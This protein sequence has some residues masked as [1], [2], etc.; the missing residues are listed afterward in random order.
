MYVVR[1]HNSN[2]YIP[3]FAFKE[4]LLQ[5]GK[6]WQIGK[7]LLPAMNT[8]R[9]EVDDVSFPG[10]P[11]SDAGWPRREYNNILLSYNNVAF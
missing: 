11:Q 6:Q 9:Y 10:K 7:N 3:P 5:E 2:E 4:C 1:H 8:N